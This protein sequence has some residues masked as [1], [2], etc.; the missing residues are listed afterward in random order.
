MLSCNSSGDRPRKASG[1]ET[2]DRH[3]TREPQVSR[4]DV[5][6]RRYH[7][8]TPALRR[9]TLNECNGDLSTVLATEKVTPF[10]PADRLAAMCTM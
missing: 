6:I 3:V 2:D 10:D 9:T 4:I 8:L 5:V 7:S 1:I